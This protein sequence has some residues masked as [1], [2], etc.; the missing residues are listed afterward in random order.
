MVLKQWGSLLPILNPVG[1]W[2]KVELI[3]AI[4]YAY[5]W[6]DGHATLKWP[7]PLCSEG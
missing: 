6:L 5:G 2:K 4:Q 1:A 7:G 3:V